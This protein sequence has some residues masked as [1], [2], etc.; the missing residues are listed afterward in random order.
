M[1]IRWSLQ[2]VFVAFHKNQSV[3]TVLYDLTI[4]IHEGE[5]VAIVG[6]NGSGK[7]T[8]GRVLAG[9]L[10]VS[11]GT[12]RDQQ[13]EK[14]FAPLV[15]QNPEA[16]ILGETVEEDVYFGLDCRGFPTEQ[17]QDRAQKALSSV[18]LWNLKHAL[19]AELSGGQKQ[20]LA[21]AD[22]LAI[23]SDCVVFDEATSMLDPQARQEVL[24]VVKQLHDQGKTI[25]WI[26]QWLD[27]LPEASR[28]LALSNG[29]IAFSGTPR[30]FFYGPLTTDSPETDARE[31]NSLE[32]NIET[33]PPCE[34]LGF[35]PPYAIAVARELHQMGRLEKSRP[36][37]P[38]ELAEAFQS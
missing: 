36:L 14:P 2:Q 25:V 18:H 32:A 23:S 24:Q 19:V 20:R 30:E 33:V 37:T 13:G 16:Q 8:L 7:S 15:F 29:R 35:T 22:A 3:H 5:W 12:V 6:P 9:L 4:E 34:V 28:V 27:E 21:I 11:R 17:M 1:T 31:S 26:T 38:A 10:D